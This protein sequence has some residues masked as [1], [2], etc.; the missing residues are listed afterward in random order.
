MAQQFEFNRHITLNL[1]VHSIQEDWPR[2]D[3]FSS[4]FEKNK[5]LKMCF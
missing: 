5:T 1:N 2:Y 3:F 4:S